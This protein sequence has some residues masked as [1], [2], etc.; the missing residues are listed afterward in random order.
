MH[1][2]GLGDSLDRSHIGGT[3]PNGLDLLWL[4]LTTKCNLNCVHCYADSGSQVAQHNGLEL[5]DW[6]EA[7]QQ[8]SQLGCGHITFIGGEPTLCPGLPDLLEY[9]RSLKLESIEVFTNGCTISNRLKEAFRRYAVDLAFSV[10]AL[11]EKVHDAITRR[12]GSLVKTLSS[13]RW[14]LD[15][16][17]SVRVGI[18]EME[19]NAAMT[20]ATTGA[21]REMGVASVRVDHVRGIGRGLSKENPPQSL[22]NELCGRCGRNKLCLAST[23]QL[24]PCVFSRFHPVGSLDLGLAAALEGLEMRSFLSTLEAVRRD[25][26]PRAGGGDHGGCDPDHGGCDPDKDCDPL[27][28]PSLGKCDPFWEEL[29]GPDT[30]PKPP[31]PGPP[32]G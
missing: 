27:C 21:L 25:V 4:E 15:A 1:T 11:D 32:R 17:L 9:G 20:K 7:M 31:Q 30:K 14:A 3:S 10:Y 18:I 13:I 22:I 2:Q 6:M 5:R 16:R 26:R 8:A 12:A 19:A 29:C 23:G 24:F 28:I